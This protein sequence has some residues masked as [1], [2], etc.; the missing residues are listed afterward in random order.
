MK[1]E[2]ESKRWKHPQEQPFHLLSYKFHVIIFTAEWKSF[3]KPV[4]MLLQE[5]DSEWIKE[6]INLSSTIWWFQT[7]EKLRIDRINL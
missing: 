2:Y 5:S 1:I 4:Q 6:Y 7:S 3:F